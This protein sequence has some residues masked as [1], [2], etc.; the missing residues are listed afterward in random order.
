[1]KKIWIIATHKKDDL[2]WNIHKVSF[3]YTHCIESTQK[4]IPFI[5][6]TNT[7]NI[8]TYIDMFDAF[9]IPG[10][11]DIHPEIYG[12]NINESE[13][14][15]KEHDE[16]LIQLLEKVTKKEKPILWI[17]KWLQII[18]VFF[19]WTLYQNIENHMHEN[20]IANEIHNIGIEKNSFLFEIF[21]QKQIP[22]NS[23]HHQCIKKLWKNLVIS[24][25]STNDNIIEAIEHT[26]L[27]IYAVQW[28]PECLN[29]HQKI[30]DWFIE[31]IK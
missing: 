11:N 12:E 4:A 29:S 9:I 30:F 18:N 20:N 17:C 6:P 8:D 23:I 16:F 7:K 25:V 13:T 2:L 1:M 15:I 28:H 3:Y 26:A 5:I 19:G 21:K 24:G 14:P 10:G 22:V 31:K 27:P